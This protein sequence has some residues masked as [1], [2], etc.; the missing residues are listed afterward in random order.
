MVRRIENSGC[1]YNSYHDEPYSIPEIQEEEV[2][3][4]FISYNNVE[5]EQVGIPLGDGTFIHEG[6]VPVSEVV[7][8]NEIT[9]FTNTDVEDMEVSR[10]STD[11]VVKDLDVVNPTSIINASINVD[12]S[13]KKSNVVLQFSDGSTKVYKKSNFEVSSWLFNKCVDE[14]FNE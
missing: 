5:N 8:N 3:P 4:V 2:T 1:A 11:L 14:N 6:E 12:F 9:C 7:T 10:L 13:T